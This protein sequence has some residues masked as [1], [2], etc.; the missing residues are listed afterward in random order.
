MAGFTNLTQDHLDYHET[1]EEYFKAKA[2]LFD[3]Q[4]SAR[5][6]IV[7]DDEWGQRLSGGQRG[8]SGC[9]SSPLSLAGNDADWLATS[10]VG[11]SPASAP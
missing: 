11:L 7:V 5:G 10:R 2:L 4:H 1:L 3:E 8:A 9:A 6:V